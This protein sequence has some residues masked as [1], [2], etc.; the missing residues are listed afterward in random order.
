MNRDV[1]DYVL[2]NET[3]CKFELILLSDLITDLPYISFLPTPPSR[4]P[5]LSAFLPP[6]FPLP[7]M[8]NPPQ[9][10]GIARPPPISFT[11][12]TPTATASRSVNALRN[13]TPGATPIPPSLQ[14][15]MAAVSPIRCHR[16]LSSP[17]LLPPFTSFSTFP[18]RPRWRTAPHTV[19]LSMLMQQPLRSDMSISEKGRRPPCGPRP[20]A[21]LQHSDAPVRLLSEASPFVAWVAETYQG[22]TWDYKMPA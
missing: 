20:R 6:S 22:W 16:F 1:I 21:P 18:V 7:A 3:E 17:H 15:K 13:R 2:Y 10:G 4:P 14:A 19:I 5:S 12:R 11:A 8:S 9:D